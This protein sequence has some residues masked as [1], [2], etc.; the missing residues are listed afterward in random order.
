MVCGKL[1]VEPIINLVGKVQMQK[2][3]DKK[4]A[5]EK[6]HKKEIAKWWWKWKVQFALWKRRLW[7][8]RLWPQKLV[9]GLK[10]RKIQ[11]GEQIYSYNPPACRQHLNSSVIQKVFSIIIE[12]RLLRQC[13]YLVTKSIRNNNINGV[14]SSQ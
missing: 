3:K 7:S 11:K 9:S 2:K 8:F 6:L 14:S 12:K 13:F 4:M 10:S 5:R 1:F